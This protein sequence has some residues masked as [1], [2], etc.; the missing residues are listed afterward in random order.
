M[1]KRLDTNRTVLRKGE[2]QRSDGR[3]DFRWTDANGKRHS[4]YAPTLKELRQREKEIELDNLQNINT[5]NR[6]LIVNDMYKRWCEVKRGIKDNTLQNYKYMYESFVQPSKLGRK[7][8]SE[9][10]KSDIKAFFNNL[11][12]ERGIRASTLDSVQTVLYQVFNLAVEDDYLRSNP[13][14]N[15]LKELKR[16]Y[17]LTPEKRK[18]LTLEEERIFLGF[19]RQTPTY[20]HWYPVFAVMLGTGMRVSETVGLRWE[21]I[22][23]DAGM[24]NVNHTLVYYKHATDGCYQNVHTPKSKAGNRMIAMQDFVKEA[25]LMEKAYQ[26][27]MDL[28]CNVTIDGYTNFIFVNRNGA[29]QH[30]GTLN[31]AI[32]R[33]TKACNNEI[34]EQHPDE[35]FPI[36]LP[37]FSC[38]TLR[39][40]FTTRMVEAGVNLKVIQDTLGHADIS[41][42]LNI[43]ADVTKEARMESAKQLENFY[44]KNASSQNI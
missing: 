11:V 19:L 34:I 2:S 32:R 5:A 25:F 35:E 1:K 8:I 9:V 41:T 7:R 30:Q 3:Y 16:A 44:K 6:Y 20:K 24:I 29:T 22:D 33:I 10:K 37:H 23:F 36:L 17:N 14:A 21:D 12:E 42:T 28:H 40:T 43:Y 31:K 13:S 27:A 39:H 26:E 15:A 18:A 38:H 4:I